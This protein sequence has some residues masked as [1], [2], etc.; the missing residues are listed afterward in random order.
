MLMLL[1]LLWRDRWR[2]CIHQREQH[3]YQ[4]TSAHPAPLVKTEHAKVVL[5]VAVVLE[6]QHSAQP[7]VDLSH[8]DSR[9]P[10]PVLQHAPVSDGDHLIAQDVGV[11]P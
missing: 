8:G 5:S 7:V 3:P 2:G 1:A 11:D 9:Q 6:A 4:G 10:A